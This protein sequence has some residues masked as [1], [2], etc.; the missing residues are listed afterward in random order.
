MA[1]EEELAKRDAAVSARDEKIASLTA[2][3]TAKNV[4]G[5]PLYHAL[6]SLISDLGAC[7]NVV[8]VVTGKQGKRLAPPFVFYLFCAVPRLP[9]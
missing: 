7:R 4:R 1:A 5:G 9:I 2:D 8:E 6:L 3:L